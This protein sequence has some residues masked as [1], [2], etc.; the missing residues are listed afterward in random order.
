[1]QCAL[2]F[3]SGSDVIALKYVLDASV[4]PFDQSIGLVRSWSGQAVFEVQSY[5]EFAEFVFTAWCALAQ[6]KEA[7]YDLFSARHWA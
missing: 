1:M 6:A 7:F 3:L 5:P 4:E 2:Q